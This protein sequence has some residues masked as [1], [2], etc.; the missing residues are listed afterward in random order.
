LETE[1]EVG[2]AKPGDEKMNWCGSTGTFSNNSFKYFY[3]SEI[4]IP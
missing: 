4:P 2:A 3:N 1:Y